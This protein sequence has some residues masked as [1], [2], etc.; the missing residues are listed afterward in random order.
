MIKRTNFGVILIG[1]R[2][3]FS[4]LVCTKISEVSTKRLFSGDLLKKQC[5]L[6]K[7][8]VSKLKLRF[9]SPR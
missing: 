4:W 1:G 8:D 5:A 2:S 3:C 7:S 6:L 9:W